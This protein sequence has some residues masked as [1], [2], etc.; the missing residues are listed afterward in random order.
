MYKKVRDRHDTGSSRRRRLNFWPPIVYSR[1][2]YT[3][4]ISSA[5]VHRAAHCSSELQ[6][7]L[8]RR[9]ITPITRTWK[10]MVMTTSS[11]WQWCVWPQPATSHAMV[12]SYTTTLQCP[13]YSFVCI[14]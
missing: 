12:T 3:L 8:A 13:I 5:C 1:S 14:S 11:V 10:L 9:C 6:S 7:T 4:G 2:K